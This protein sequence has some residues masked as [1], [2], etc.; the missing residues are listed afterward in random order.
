[1]Q[2]QHG[3]APPP[4]GIEDWRR[5][6][7]LFSHFFARQNAEKTRKNAEKMRKNAENLRRNRAFLIGYAEIGGKKP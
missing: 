5:K 3:L 2:D 1:M 4:E 6:N 7:S